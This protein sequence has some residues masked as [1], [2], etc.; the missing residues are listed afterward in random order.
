MRK[1]FNKYTSLSD[2]F[3]FIIVAVIIGFSILFV[4]IFRAIFPLKFFS[5]STGTQNQTQSSN[6]S[7]LI[8]SPSNDAVFKFANVNESVSIEVA[9]KDIETLD[10]KLKIVIN[11]EDVKTFNSPPYQF[12]WIPEKSGSYELVA[13]LVDDSDKVISSSNKVKFSVEYSGETVETIARSIDIEEKK[14]NA[15]N[16]SEYRS[17]NGTPVFS[18]KCYTP[19]AIDG[20]I[21]EWTVYD[22]A[23]ISNPTIKKEN[24]TTAS[25]CSGILYTCWD[26]T[27]FYFAVS[28]TDDVFNQKNTGS[29]I[30]NG[31]SI[32]LVFDTDLSGD[33]NIPFYNSDDFH[34]DFSP[35]SFT[36]IP[37][38]AFIYFPSRNPTGIEIKSSQIK[39]GYVFEAM[40]PWENFVSFGPKD[41]DVLGF[42]ASIFD[43]DNLD[44]TELAVSTSLNFEINNLSTLGTLVFIDGGDLLADKT[45]DSAA[46]SADT[47][48]AS[49]N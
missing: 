25:D 2:R 8:A 45:T 13:N 6:Y 3:P 18:F 35:G 44:T 39:N 37:P 10:Y 23:S 1:R 34:I 46:D 20:N 16:N 11:D 12:N 43:T 4:L 41:L 27:A 15:L 40:I 33:F 32:T 47:T 30:N 17:F 22:K 48:G 19:P 42:T 49:G 28:V 38:E 36:G 14:S 31:D 7:I 9:A 24:F 26:D 29:Q 5:G 21:D